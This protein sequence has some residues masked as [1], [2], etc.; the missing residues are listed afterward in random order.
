MARCLT[1]KYEISAVILIIAYGNSLRTDDAAGLHLAQLVEQACQAQQ[2]AVE[3][4][5]TH[6][7]LP[8]LAPEIARAETA[9]FVDTRAVPP[10]EIEP[11]VQI[12]PVAV[13][14]SPASLGHH[15]SPAALLAYAG[16]LYGCRPPAWLL[17]APGTDFAH[18]EGLSQTAQQALAAAGPVVARLL[19]QIEPV[20]PAQ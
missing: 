2:L 10:Q 20:Q 14:I 19:A 16:L 13:D 17:T 7:L 4:I 3:K 11:A 15:L 5:I 1:K 18:G 8:E 12:Q 6:Q 9:L